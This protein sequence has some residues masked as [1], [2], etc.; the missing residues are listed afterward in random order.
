M[1]VVDG[2]AQVLRNQ[3]QVALRLA[4]VEPDDGQEVLLLTPPDAIPTVGNCLTA[5][6]SCLTVVENCLTAVLA[7]SLV[8]THRDPRDPV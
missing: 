5:G 6:A 7:T 2:L 8:G 3:L 4:A 1:A